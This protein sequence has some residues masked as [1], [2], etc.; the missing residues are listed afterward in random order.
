MTDLGNVGTYPGSQ[1]LGINSRRQIVGNLLDNI[2]N[3]IGGFLWD[4]AGY[5]VGN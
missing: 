5:M 3:E 4:I 1:A 2:G